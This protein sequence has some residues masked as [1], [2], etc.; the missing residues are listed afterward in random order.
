MNVLPNDPNN[1]TCSS[2]GL[3]AQPTPIFIIQTM[4]D[5]YKLKSYP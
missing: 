2:C 1:I 4:S 3:H 5:L